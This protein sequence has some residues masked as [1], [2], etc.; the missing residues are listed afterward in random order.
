MTMKP[1]PWAHP[2]PQL[3]AARDANRRARAASRFDE[4]MAAGPAL[5]A[6]L[7]ETQDTPVCRLWMRLLGDAPGSSARWQRRL[8]WDGWSVQAACAALAQPVELPALALQLTQL[9]PALDWTHADGR[10]DWARWAKQVFADALPA[11]SAAER[12]SLRPLQD[13]LSQHFALVGSALAS[14][15]GSI[16]A[17]FETWPVLARQLAEARAQA[18]AQLST[19]WQRLHA[20][21]DA[22]A[23]TF[24]AEFG[25]WPLRIS[26]ADCDRHRDGQ[27]V[28]RLEFAGG[29]LYFK[30]RCLRIDVAFAEVCRALAA[31]ALPA[32]PALPALA[33]DGYGYQAEACAL[34]DP[35]VLPDSVFEDFG[36]LLALAWLGNARDLHRD[37]LLLTAQGLQLFDLETLLQ[38]ER[39]A[40][41]VYENGVLAN[42]LLDFRCASSGQDSAGIGVLEQA[43]GRHLTEDEQSRIDSGFRR[44]LQALRTTDTQALLTPLL[45]PTLMLRVVYRPSAV[46]A[47]VLAA[48]REPRALGDGALGILATDSLH[49]PLLDYPQPP[50]EW[51]LA[52]DERAQLERGDIPLFELPAQARGFSVDGPELFVRSAN[53]VLTQRLGALHSHVIDA[54]VQQLRTALQLRAQLHCSGLAGRLAAWRGQPAAPS[55]LR[56]VA[57]ELLAAV[58]ADA[59]TSTLSDPAPDLDDTGVSSTT[60]LLQSLR[61]QPLP[62]ALDLDGGV[63]GLLFALAVH[64]LRAPQAAELELAERCA[65]ALLQP[66]LPVGYSGQPQPGL[67]HGL[68]GMALALG[69]AARAFDQPHWRR[70][71][72]QLCAAEDAMFDPHTANW[73][74]T[75]GQPAALNAWCNGAS[76]VLLARA[77]LGMGLN[78]PAA[79]AARAA[80]PALPE[81]SVDHLCCGELGRLLA[82]QAIAR[83]TADNPLATAADARFDTLQQRWAQRRERL[84]QPRGLS[85][86]RGVRGL[87]WGW[88]AYRDVTL[89]NPALLGLRWSEL[90]D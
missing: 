42:G 87:A 10:P 55:L 48:L 81:A 34:S 56:G 13:A 58:Q 85:L 57:G 82:W 16:F 26:A 73:P 2:I 45:E 64:A 22:R 14:H 28:L 77:M 75:P 74:A 53:E 27:Q 8:A 65:M 5:F 70:R 67:A 88:S 78:S 24:G 59:R 3:E 17:A 54:Q 43:L 4:R 76:G 1:A 23:Q 61:E 31:A 40:A 68:A 44:L 25:G 6:V 19:L 84:D 39:P 49:A 18:S 72:E 63:A 86:L 7:R 41:D 35:S 38:P 69:L 66:A 51:T 62:A 21:G 60:S 89:P 83:A 15:G 47:A 30:P 46:Y 79:Q 33:L 37:N 50:P 32:P 52:A 36:A 71:A 90:H 29:A 9:Q 12:A 80:L 11:A 20:D